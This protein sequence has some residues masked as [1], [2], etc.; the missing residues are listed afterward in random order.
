MSLA[1]DAP[2]LDDQERLRLAEQK[3]AELAPYRDG[4]SDGQFAERINQETGVG[5]DAARLVVMGHS[6]TR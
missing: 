3:Y 1:T 5:S 2:V 4:L 6:S